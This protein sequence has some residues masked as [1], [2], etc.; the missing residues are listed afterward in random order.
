MPVWTFGTVEADPE[1]RLVRWRVLGASYIDGALPPTRH[2]VGACASGGAGRV[3]FALETLD[4]G[5]RRGLTHSGRAYELI[6][7]PNRDSGAE[8]LWNMWCRI[9][10]VNTWVDVTRRAF[11]TFDGEPTDAEVKPSIKRDVQ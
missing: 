9:N 7:V 8:Q 10:G 11:V 2:F 5:A 1:V 4:A 6:G 3:S